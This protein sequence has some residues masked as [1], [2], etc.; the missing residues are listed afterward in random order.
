[1]I[2]LDSDSDQLGADTTTVRD[3]RTDQDT[4]RPTRVNNWARSA[5]ALHTLSYRSRLRIS[6]LC[7]LSIIQI[8]LLLNT[9]TQAIPFKNPSSQK[10]VNFQYNNLFFKNWFFCSHRTLMEPSNNNLCE[11]MQNL[12]ANNPENDTENEKQSEIEDLIAELCLSAPS[13]NVKF[14]LRNYEYGKPLQTILRDFEKVKREPLRDTAQYLR[15]PNV[16]KTKKA[17]AHLIVCR[18]QNLLPDKCFLCNEHYRISNTEVPILECAICGQGVHKECWVDIASTMMNPNDIPE[19]LNADTFKA[20]FNPLKLPGMFYICNACQPTTIPSDETGNYKRKNKSSTTAEKQPLLPQTQVNSNEKEN[21]LQLERQETTSQETESQ[22]TSYQSSA[23]QD[24]RRYESDELPSAQPGG[25]SSARAAEAE[26]KHNEQQ[27]FDQSWNSF[28]AEE[29]NTQVVRRE[30]L[31]E[32]EEPKSKSEVLCRHFREGNCKHGMKGRECK[33]NHP[34]VC[35]K[36]TQ[37]GTRQPRGCAKGR[38]CEHFHPKMCMD[39]LRKGEC[40]T[41]TCRFN[42]VKGTKRHPPVRKIN[43]EENRVKGKSGEDNLPRKKSIVG[44]NNDTGSFLEM[45]SL[46]KQEILE[47][48]NQK[49]TSIQSQIQQIHQAQSST[50]PQAAMYQQTQLPSTNPVLYRP[51]HPQTPAPTFPPYFQPVYRQ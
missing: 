41:E 43:V 45:I 11:N 15:L 13:E 2:D 31:S 6:I 51:A 40:F 22:K 38:K 10:E 50:F 48:L 39:S 35:S 5:Y 17:L 4:W 3:R 16:D 20:L 23:D 44:E 25:N 21:P 12:I 24:T 19:E 37:H 18:I 27:H 26:A 29:D 8:I 30:S 28:R 32:P 7:I 14:C 42:H 1:M 47:T 9:V 49:I 34:K 46:L 36:F 33:Y